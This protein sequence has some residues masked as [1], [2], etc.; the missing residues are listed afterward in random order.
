MINEALVF[1]KK[2]LNT[3]LSLDRDPS[4]SHEDVVTFVAGDQMDPLTFKLGTVTVLLVNVEEDNVLR[5][6][7]RYG[8]ISSDGKRQEVQPEIRLNLFVLFV[9]R[10]KQYEDAL[11]S[12]SQI[13]QYFQNNRV[14][15]HQLAPELSENIEKL[16]MEL[17]T[18]P[19]SEQ[20]EIWGSLRV[21]Y[22]PSVLY[23]TKMIVYR[24]ESQPDMPKVE[25]KSVQVSQ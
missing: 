11:R 17:V 8:R 15:D 9:A 23:K 4:Q 18:L 2:R 7:D 20:N 10:Y 16:V 21:P 22:Q 13:I 5:S 6:P 14:F 3:H 1:L 19:F 24:T 25:E 12:L